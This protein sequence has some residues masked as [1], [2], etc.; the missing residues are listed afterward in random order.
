MS[1]LYYKESI[2]D[3]ISGWAKCINAF[4]RDS[5]I[6]ND[7]LEASR[8]VDIPSVCSSQL[9]ENA[10]LNSP[11]NKSLFNHQEQY[12][13]FDM[14]EIIQQTSN[15][16]QQCVIRTTGESLRSDTI[17]PIISTN[18]L[19]TMLICLSIVFTG[20]AYLPMDR[21]NPQN[22][23]RQLL[24]ENKVAYYIA[25]EDYDI[26]S[27]VAILNEEL[28]KCVPKVGSTFKHRALP[29]DLAYVIF[30]SG[31]T[32]KPKGVTIKHK[33]VINLAQQSAYNFSMASS[34][35]VYQFT[36]FIFDN[37]ILEMIM[38]LSNTSALFIEER[39]FSTKVFLREI[40]NSHITHALLFPGL[41]EMFTCEEVALFAYLRYW[42]VGAEKLSE[43]LMS[44]AL[45]NG[46]PPPMR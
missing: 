3:M 32:G 46:K 30:T 1:S 35:C 28:F 41:V 44:E 36:N 26:N 42:I 39:S 43:R 21:T 29:D 5:T 6:H 33:A 19:R 2:T 20:A 40:H 15:A 16:L 12:N 24:E 38:A 4:E 11:K 7:H 17:I 18:S 34:D 22:R 45:K 37:S 27:I 31:T 25:E 8:S 14:L 10:S 13:Y 23:I 9:I